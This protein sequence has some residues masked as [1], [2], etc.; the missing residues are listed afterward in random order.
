MLPEA[1]LGPQNMQYI[2]LARWDT[3]PQTLDLPGV[4]N[5]WFALP[6]P[7][8]AAQFRGR[9]QA[10]NGDAPHALAGLS[11]DAIA[12]IG[13]LA[14]SGKGDALTRNA[15]TQSAGFQG[16]TGIFRFRPD[17]TTDRG[18]AVASIRD[19]QVV[20][21]SPAPQAFRGSGF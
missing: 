14:K 15:L 3:P 18:L 10:A 17:G 12:A 11:Y 20:V 1:G 6:D 9:F 19:R 21:I 7:Q 8:R 2:G 13:A 5:G 16:V 4:Q